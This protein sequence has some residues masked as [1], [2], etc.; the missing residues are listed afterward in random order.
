MSQTVTITCDVCGKQK[1][2]SNSWFRIVH[3]PQVVAVWID[4]EAI[5]ELED[6]EAS[7]DLCG[8][9]CAL[10]LI[11]KKLEESRNAR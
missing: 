11:Q 10:R 9:E 7:A 6:G 4:S 8:E 1:G 2:P 3:G 5:L